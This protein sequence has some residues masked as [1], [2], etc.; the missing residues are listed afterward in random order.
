MK[1]SEEARVKG[2][3]GGEKGNYIQLEINDLKQSRI[4]ARDAA[5]AE[6]MKEL[7]TEIPG[8]LKNLKKLSKLKSTIDDGKIIQ[9]F[10][11]QILDVLPEN[12]H[13]LATET[14]AN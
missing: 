1:R 13:L 6:R 5:I 12:I 10:A 4:A 2:L 7:V 8:G 11:I 9:D 14:D 3:K